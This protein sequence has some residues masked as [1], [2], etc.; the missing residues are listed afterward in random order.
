MSRS[1][2]MAFVAMSERQNSLPATND[3]PVWR[4]P[5]LQRPPE[6]D[7]FEGKWVAVVEGRVVASA[8]TSHELD[9]ELRQWP[10][11]ELKKVVMQ[12]V[13]PPTDCSIVYA[14]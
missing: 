6:L 11:D 12:Y 4:V 13:H 8:E 1:R 3:R 2:R 10:P 9:L 5:P 7:A 14:R